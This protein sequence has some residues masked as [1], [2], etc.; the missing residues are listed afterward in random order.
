MIEGFNS[1]GR[2]FGGVG[3]QIVFAFFSFFYL[4]ALVKSIGGSGDNSHVGMSIFCGVSGFIL[5]IPLFIRQWRVVI[6]VD[7]VS[8]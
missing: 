7:L 2:A 5:I 3:V 6:W 8:I 4:Y 1:D